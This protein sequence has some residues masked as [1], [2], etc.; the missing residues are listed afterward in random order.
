MKKLLTLCLGFIP[1]AALAATNK[2][3][4]VTYFPVPYV[5]YSQLNATEQMDIGLTNS[6]DMT[7]GCS[8][9]SATLNAARVN[10]TG[11]K[12]NLDGGRGIKG[13]TLSLGNGNGTGKISFQN[14]RIHTGT[15]ESMNAGDIKAANLNLFGKAFPSC[16]S[17]NSESGGQMQWTSLKLKGA[18]SSELYLACGNLTA[19]ATCTPT[20]NGQETYIESCPLGQ[21]GSKRY[22]WNYATCKYT[23]TS[24]TCKSTKK[25]CLSKVMYCGGHDVST[26]AINAGEKCNVWD[27][28]MQEGTENKSCSRYK[29]GTAIGSFTGYALPQEVYSQYGMIS[30]T[31]CTPGTECNTCTPGKKYIKSYQGQG[32][33]CY[34]TETAAYGPGSVRTL[35]LVPY[36]LCGEMNDCS[37]GAE[38]SCTS[39]KQTSNSGNPLPFLPAEPELKI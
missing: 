6:C 3:S 25:T 19:S 1:C 18:S 31:G 23:L 35:Y 37:E 27:R 38:V 39:W 33:C 15:M 28:P 11:G 30:S 13:N 17:A 16:K 7:L 8:E 9:T 26:G 32:T 29:L 12:L 10:L 22:T 14:V 20:N 2:I 36:A 4:M 5:A 34:N 21:I 24:N